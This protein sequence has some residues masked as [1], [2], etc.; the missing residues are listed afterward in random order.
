MLCVLIVHAS[1]LYHY[2]QI[3]NNNNDYYYYY[4]YVRGNNY[5]YLVRFNSIIDGNKEIK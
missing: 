5:K 4:Y 2:N 3:Y 1:I